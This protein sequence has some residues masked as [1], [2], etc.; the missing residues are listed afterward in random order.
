MKL[1]PFRKL[2]SLPLLLAGILFLDCSSS[3]K[4]SREVDVRE[5]EKDF[6]PEKYNRKETLEVKKT[7]PVQE[8]GFSKS[9]NS[10]DKFEKIPGYRVQI[11]STN[12]VDEATSKKEELQTMLDSLKVYLVYDAP[13]YKIRVGDCTNREEAA[14]LRDQLR[15]NGLAEAWIVPDQ[16]IHIFP[17]E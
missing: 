6:D 13:Y 8:A 4:T 14:I 10:R 11:L 15:E 17:E 7:E 12:N 2:V 3:T 16:I 1:L 5:Y 9:R